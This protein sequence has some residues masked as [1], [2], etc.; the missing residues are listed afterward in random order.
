MAWLAPMAACALAL[1]VISQEGGAGAR[2]TS[3]AGLNFSNDSLAAYMPAEGSSAENHVHR[4]TF[5]W[6][7]RGNSNSSV[8]SMQ[9]KNAAD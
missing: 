4:V 5:E 9:L 3:L 6:T 7:N 2:A 1:A 8:G